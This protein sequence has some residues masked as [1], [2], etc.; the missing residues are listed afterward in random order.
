MPLDLKREE[1]RDAAA[2]VCREAG[3]KGGRGVGISREGEGGLEG[4]GAYLAVEPDAARILVEPVY[5]TLRGWLV[6]EVCVC[7]GA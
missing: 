6:V 2:L 7:Q 3:R 5:Q 1:R 4:G